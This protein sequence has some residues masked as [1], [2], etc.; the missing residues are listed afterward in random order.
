MAQRLRADEKKIIEHLA[1]EIN[2]KGGD[3]CETGKPHEHL[4][5][6]RLS[7]T[8]ETRIQ[9]NPKHL[10]FVAN[11]LGLTG[12]KTRPTPGVLSHRATMDATP[13]CDC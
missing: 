5:R 7:M 3:R 11:Q 13:L 6:L 12:A 10:E 1:L 4:K 8:G 2:F 9:P